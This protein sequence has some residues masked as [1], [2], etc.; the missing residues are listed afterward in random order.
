[1]S[2][3]ERAGHPHDPDPVVERVDDQVVERLT[4]PPVISTHDRRPDRPAQLDRTA[5][6]LGEPGPGFRAAPHDRA[7]LE[8]LEPP[9]GPASKASIVH[10][11]DR[12]VRA[13]G[14]G[15]QRV[16]PA[17]DRRPRTAAL[18]REQAELDRSQ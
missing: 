6:R 3:G 2:L 1:M 13:L 10:V 16:H 18:E 5:A 9:G 11:L 14:L 7:E 8:Q 4:D 17:R 15:A 12:G